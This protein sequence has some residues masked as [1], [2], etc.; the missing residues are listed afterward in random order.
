MVDLQI[1][2][3][4]AAGL[5]A[6]LYAARAGLSVRVFDRAGGGGQ[7]TEAAEICN[8]PGVGRISGAALA[9]EFCR[10]ATCAGAELIT[11]EVTRAELITTKVTPAERSHG[12]EGAGG[13]RVPELHAS[14]SDRTRA[15]SPEPRAAH[16]PRDSGGFVLYSGGERSESAALILA[17]GASP[18]RLAVPGER[19]YLGKGVSYCAV[20]DGRFFGGKTVAVIGGGDSALSE[21]LYLS[22]I[23]ARV[24][25]IHRRGEFRGDPALLSRLSLLPQVIFHPERTISAIRGGKTVERIEL[26]RSDGTPAETLAVDGVFA[27]I[28]RVPENGRFANLIE[29]DLDGYFRVGE[30]CRTRIPGLFAAGDTRQKPLRQIIFSAADGALA[31]EHAREYLS[32][33]GSRH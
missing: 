3:G 25:L 26:C 9:K 4:G 1:V 15:V 28:G 23:A 30:D 2:G 17:N 18:R 16:A 22:S 14:P 29:S 33:A 21:A 13:D 7:M 27:A 24:H 10:A 11:A 8:Y 6:A 19:E 5:T 20:C 32:G 31:A 12:A